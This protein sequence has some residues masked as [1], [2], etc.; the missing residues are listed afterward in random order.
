MSFTFRSSWFSL[1]LHDPAF[2]PR[3]A[4]GKSLVRNPERAP[5]RSGIPS[6]A[7]RP[8]TATWAIREEGPAE[9]RRRD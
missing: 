7:R 3:I 6:R 8:R 4:P 1:A 9:K 2:R 5:E